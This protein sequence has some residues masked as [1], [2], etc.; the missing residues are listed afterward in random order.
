MRQCEYSLTCIL[1]PASNGF[2]QAGLAT[3]AE[4]P[5]LRMG[6]DEQGHFRVRQQVQR[7]RSPGLGA[8]PHRRAVPTISVISGKAEAHWQ[9]GDHSGIMKIL[10]R[11]LHPVAKPRS[12]RIFE[13]HTRAISLVAWCLARNENARIGMQLKNRVRRAIHLAFAQTASPNSCEL[14]FKMERHGVSYNS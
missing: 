6:T 12:R 14:C 9:D 4:V 11:Y 2:S 8:N 10:L 7:L 13:G 5:S 1:L 3:C